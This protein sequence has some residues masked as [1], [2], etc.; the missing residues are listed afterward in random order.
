MRSHWWVMGV[1]L[2]L[3]GGACKTTPLES[4]A[5]PKGEAP[6]STE[7][8]ALI[9]EA[10]DPCVD[11]Y[12]YACGQWLDETVRPADQPRYGR[13]H[14][15]RERNK[16]AQ[17]TILEEDAA[18]ANATG[19]AAKLGRF[20]ATCMDEAAVETAGI[21][22][23]APLLEAIA[24][25]K[26]DAGLMRVLAQ[27]QQVGARPLFDL[28]VDAGYE[29]PEITSVHVD[30]GGLGLP[31]RRYYLDEG[32]A[33]EALRA[34]YVEHVAEILDALGEPDAPQRAAEVVALETELARVSIP[35][36]QIRDPDQRSNPMTVA[37]LAKLTPTLPW[38]AYLEAAGIPEP[39][40]LNVVAPSYVEAMG[41][42]VAGAEWPVRR[43]YLRWQLGH[44]LA[45]HLPAR[46]AKADFEMYDLRLN[47]QAEPTPR[48][49]RCVETTDGVLGESLGRQFVERY[50]AGD[51]GRIAEEMIGQIEQAFAAALPGLEW[52]DAPTR[53]RA[54]EKMHAIVNKIGHPEQWRDYSA[55]EVGSVH[56]ANVM[57]GQRFEW[58]R[59]AAQV[60]GPVDRGEWH[61]T[62]PTVNAYYNPSGNEMVFPAGILQPPFFS[63]DNPMA[64]NFGGI[65]M[66]MGHELTHGFDDGGR[67]FDGS[68]RLTEWWGPDAVSR[69]EERATCVEQL[70][71]TYEIQPG[72][73]LN[74]KLTLGENIA[75]LGGIRQAHGAYQAWAAA[76]GGDA[77][78]AVEGLT[79]EQLLFVAFGQIWCSHATPE[80]E[81]MLA[82][83]DTHSH[84]RY[85]V[86][87]P[88][89]SYPAF[90][91]AFSCEE[92]TPMHP[93]QVCE[94]W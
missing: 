53:E 45:Q 73:H 63:A 14:E 77:T 82:T 75:D 41:K 23:L 10:A 43:A 9:D 6:L 30:Q 69:F 26:D 58:R 11:F 44:A 17:R 86:N 29:D 38:K 59:Q 46:F 2:G 83:T 31:D 56:V 47:G 40:H 81:R 1:G 12:R 89:S 60:D 16:L 4:P 34:A 18:D 88:L 3:Y 65:G 25:A 54:L 50:F 22:P 93:A 64:M 79:N 8:H 35:R 80:A 27:L 71:D 21:E 68:G 91:E 72:V 55:L 19:D 36:D 76:H 24:A 42:V 78:P 7:V 66:V 33:A 90:W 70:Y 84:A 67:K 51:S 15:L 61:M 62:P 92:G 28:D 85:R 5:D 37:E 39:K 74:G 52:M 94:V 48:W 20:Y 87:G 32:E 49:R 57:A 13:F